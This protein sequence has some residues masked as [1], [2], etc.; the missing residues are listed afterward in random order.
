MKVTNNFIV[1]SLLLAPLSATAYQKADNI[2]QG[3]NLV[4]DDGYAIV[5][6]ADGWDK[7]SKKTAEMMMADPAVT[8]ALGNAVVMTLPVP[9]VT[10]KEEHEANKTRFG[11]MDLSFPNVYPAIILYDKTGR[12][13]TDICIPYSERKNPAA[14]AAKVS[15]AMTA[16]RKQARLLSDAETAQGVEKARLLGQASIIPGINRPNKVAD[17]IKKVDPQDESGMQRIASLNLFATAIESAS[18]KDWEADLAT[19]KALMENPLLT[20]EQKQQ[21][22][23]ICIG[24]LRRHGGLG[25][26]AEL[27]QMINKLRELDPDSLLGQSADDAE[28]MWVSTFNIVEGWSPAILPSDATPVELEGKLPISAAGTYEVTFNYKKGTE[29]LRVA[30]VE[31][32]DGDKKIAED[33]HAG[34]MGIKQNNNVYTLNVPAAVKNPR[35]FVI[36]NMGEK[37]D[38]YGKVTITRK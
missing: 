30:A 9:N 23:C 14:I 5:T 12:R 8:K 25:R 27:K 3:K 29:A 13:L 22:C 10:S 18:T 17:M 1:L 38:S 32:Y 7:Y 34:F 35:I 4:T 26:R 37:L 24:L 15:T 36:F 20:T 28:R 31:L 6:Y 21:A 11:N 19:T 16:A 33:R 2:E